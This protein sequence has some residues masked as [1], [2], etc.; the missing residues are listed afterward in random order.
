[1]SSAK[2]NAALADGRRAAAPARRTSGS[3]LNVGPG[4]IGSFVDPDG[5]PRLVTGFKH[6]LEAALEIVYSSLITGF[7]PGYSPIEITNST[8]RPHFSSPAICYLFAA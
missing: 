4:R 8:C 6:L 5:Q 2:G 1:M 3:V 7:A